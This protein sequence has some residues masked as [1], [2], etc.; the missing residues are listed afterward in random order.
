MFG[1]G[2]NDYNY[3]IG[4]REKMTLDG[5]GNLGIGAPSPEG[6]LHLGA[7]TP[8]VFLVGATTINQ[9][10]LRVHY[11]ES[12]HLRTGVIDVKG[13]SL[14]L[15]GESHPAGEGATERLFI[16]LR[17]GNVGIGTTAPEARL[18]VGGGVVA[19]DDLHVGG[20][21]VADDDVVARRYLTVY[22]GSVFWGSCSFIGGIQPPNG[23]ITE[24]KGSVTIEHELVVFYPSLPLETIQ[25][26][27]SSRPF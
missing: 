13:L 17:S 7:P 27:P 18:H 14:R 6:T 11:N 16:D 8:N 10:G 3:G 4:A 1:V 9:D 5:S 23:N 12:P 2:G 26:R 21:V 20:G 25:D 22:E 19:D 15:R 24:I